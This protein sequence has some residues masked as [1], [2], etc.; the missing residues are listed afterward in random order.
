M[1]NRIIIM[2]K[3]YDGQLAERSPVPETRLPASLEVLV[4]LACERAIDPTLS[5]GT[6]S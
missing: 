1:K 2:S 3:T 6:Q 5:I 4:T